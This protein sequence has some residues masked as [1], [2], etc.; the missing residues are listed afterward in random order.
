[1]KME[2]TADIGSMEI[3]TGVVDWELVF[4]RYTPVEELPF[5]GIRRYT[6][7]LLPAYETKY[8]C[9]W[10]FDQKDRS[11]FKMNENGV[12][13][14]FTDGGVRFLLNIK[15]NLIE[16]EGCIRGE[17]VLES[18]KKIEKHLLEGVEI[19]ERRTRIRGH[20]SSII[21]SYVGSEYCEEFEFERINS[22]KNDRMSF[23]VM[24]SRVDTL[25]DRERFILKICE[26]SKVIYHEDMFSCPGAGR[27]SAQ[28]LLESIG[29]RKIEELEDLI[30]LSPNNTRLNDDP[31]VWYSGVAR[32][33]PCRPQGS[34]KGT[35]TDFRIDPKRQI[36]FPKE[37]PVLYTAPEGF[38][39]G[40]K[41]NKVQPPEG[42]SKRYGDPYPAFPCYY[43]IVQHKR[44]RAY[45]IYMSCA[46]DHEF[47]TRM[48]VEGSRES[49]KK[50]L[51][52]PGQRG[53]IVGYEPLENIF[54]DRKRY[55]RR[56]VTSWS[57]FFQDV[58]RKVS[59]LEM[60]RC[61]KEFHHL[62]YSDAGGSLKDY[63]LRESLPNIR[64]YHPLI[65]ERTNSRVIILIRKEDRVFLY[66][67]YSPRKEFK[68]YIFVIL[69]TQ[70]DVDLGYEVIEDTLMGNELRVPKE[71]VLI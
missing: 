2:S 10:F 3:K 17:R 22:S 8:W 46:N 5:L 70:R 41:V 16:I 47:K 65:E 21:K 32:H 19:L 38:Y 53:S 30:L 42:Y 34:D 25:G 13:W 11:G 69:Y 6:E 49:S 40:L 51:L 68:H 59:D 45:I 71:S 27:C 60:E 23:Y 39:I 18:S 62:D 35:H 36:L 56:R 61:Y 43:S 33:C 15:K 37:R 67:P 66:K 55:Y 1:M 48:G 64:F 9:P 63:F 31:R 57:I 29:R 7:S 4:K 12:V 26:D 24:M 52:E 28:R 58:T 54:L 44:Q 20:M 50:T 14:G